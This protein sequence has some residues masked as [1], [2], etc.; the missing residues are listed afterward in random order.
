MIRNFF[1]KEWHEYQKLEQA[2][3]QE[4]KKSKEL[5]AICNT[6]IEENKTLKSVDNEESSEKS[7]DF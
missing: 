4:C 6:L 2:Y 7:I 1:S 5:Q 3:E